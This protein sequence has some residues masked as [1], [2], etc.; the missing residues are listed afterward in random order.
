MREDEAVASRYG[1]DLQFIA[2]EAT[3]LD[4]SLRQLLGF[5][6]PAPELNE[7]VDLAELVEAT[8]A[9]LRKQAELEGVRMEALI[10]P[11]VRHAH[12]N[13]E[14]WQ[15]I[16]LNLLLNA[17]Q[18]SPKGATV[19]VTLTAQPRFTVTDHG[20]GIPADL[21]ERVFDPFFTTKQ[22]GTGLGLAIVRRNARALGGEVMIESPPGGGASISV[23]C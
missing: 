5:S 20:P 2:S 16:V 10:E 17:L 22:K 9:A 6:R 7:D 14:L 3:R 23:A 8:V 4:N 12:G 13:R 19:T 21:R 15:Q 1:E 18:A 11:D